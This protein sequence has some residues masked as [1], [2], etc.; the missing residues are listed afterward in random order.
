MKDKQISFL[1]IE[2]G[3]L[4]QLEHYNTKLP[5]WLSVIGDFMTVALIFG[6]AW[7]LWAI[8]P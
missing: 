3:H 4:V 8:L 6:A 2:N 1:K 5:N 7:L